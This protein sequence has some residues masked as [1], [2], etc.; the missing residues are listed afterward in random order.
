M[1]TNTTTFF[2]EYAILPEQTVRDNCMTFFAGMGP[3]DDKRELGSV[4]LLGRWSTVGESRGFCIAEASSAKSMLAWLSNWTTM[5]DIKAVPVLDDNQHRALILG[6]T[7]DYTVP[8]DKVNSPPGEGESLYFIRYKFRCGKKAEGFQAFANMT[9]EMD[10]KDT[11]DC[12]SYGRW[13]VPSEGY[14]VAVASAPSA[15]AVY[16]WAYNW[17]ELCNCQVQAV[18]SD[19]ETRSV[20]RGKPGFQDKHAALMKQMGISTGPHY[21][22]ATVTLKDEE[23][24]AQFLTILD[25]PD[26]LAKTR[27]WPGN[28]HI[29]IF[30]DQENPLVVIIQQKWKQRSDHQKY[31]EH[32]V[33]TGM[34]D[35]IQEFGTLAVQHLGATSY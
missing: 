21:V 5:A 1:S 28:E 24:K 17:N 2:C 29:H 34:I 30:V 22:T 33:E 12:T 15:E 27:E 32:R 19:E 16:K 23:K 20:L 9:Q 11:G 7:P 13:H 6:K 10:A 3:E 18:T 26:G 25:S 31:Y 14:G 35:K 8:Y 4:N